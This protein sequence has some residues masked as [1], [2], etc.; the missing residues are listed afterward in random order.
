MVKTRSLD[1]DSTA[2]AY[3]ERWRI[4]PQANYYNGPV[5]IIGEYA[6][7]RQAVEL[8]DR[9]FASSRWGRFEHSNPTELQTKT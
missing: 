3:G 6:L 4:A 8:N 7:E 1:I 5:G 9:R 2:I